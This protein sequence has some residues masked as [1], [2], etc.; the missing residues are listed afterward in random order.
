MNVIILF[1]KKKHQINIHKL[2]S[3]LSIKNRVNKLIFQDKYELNDIEVYYENKILNDNDYCDKYK[4]NENGILTVHL[5]KKGGNIMKT[6]LWVLGCLIII[7]IPCF[8]LPTG[9]NTSGVTFI[10]VVL[11]KVKDGL[12][13]F[14]ICELKYK[15]LVKRF[16]GVIS[17][18]KYV[19]FIMATYVLITIGCVTACLL[20]KGKGIKDDPNKICSPY[21]VGSIAGLILTSIYFFIYILLR[22][23]EKFFEPMEKYAKKNFITNMLLVPILSGIRSVISKSKF[24]FVYILPIFGSGVMSFHKM[25]D[26]IFPE[27]MLMLQKISSAGCSANGLQS[28]LK[29]MQGDFQKLNSNMN[30]SE[31]ESM[32]NENN[33][34]NNN[35]NNNGNNNGNN[36]VESFSNMETYINYLQQNNELLRQQ[37]QLLQNR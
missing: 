26:A 22:Y 35:E 4:I 8:I 21:Y 34:G 30:E 6:I 37:V 9:I 28:V 27:L 25:I 12:S 13:R 11:N 23:S 3:I 18:F 10:S 7:L 16:T 31:Q 36:T 17:F 29:N 1:N 24:I 19:L 32:N 2:D 33:N 20:V 14:L 5:K 15:T